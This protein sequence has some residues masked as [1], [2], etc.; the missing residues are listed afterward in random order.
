MTS[1]YL[2]KIYRL[3]I[4]E[5][6]NIFV[7]QNSDSYVILHNFSNKICLI[8]KKKMK[9]RLSGLIFLLILLGIS[10]KEQAEFSSFNGF[11][12]GTTYSVVFE[13][14]DKTDPS[15]LR[16]KVEKI[17]HDFDMS[18]S[19]YQDS[20]IVSRI[21]LNENVAPDSFFIEAFT[22]SKE[23]TRITGGA[24]DI[25]VGPLVEAW[26]FGP[27]ATKN[28]TVPIRDSLMNFIG[29]DKVEIRNGMVYKADPRIRLDFNAIAQG[30]SVDILS[31]YLNSI[32]INR[33][34]VE[35]G[36]EVRV[37]G[38]KGGV[39]WRIG[40]DRP[41]DNN[42]MPGEDMQAIIS[43]KDKSLATSGNYRKF[44]IEDGIKYS[45]TIDPKTGYPA[46]NRLLS[47]T[48]IADDC[49]TADGIATACMVM[50]QANTIEFLN[51]HPEFEAYLIYSDDNG[52]FKT[53]ATQ[54][55]KEY[56]SET[57]E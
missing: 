12:Q 27:G 15:D 50:G 8:N 51:L 6:K 40:I 34:L 21:N 3:T 19:L 36:G 39:L 56:I 13:N 57:E 31:R 17:L 30:Y 28:I 45:H 33:H 46:G 7:S 32:G 47:A 44:Y 1:G 52:N 49:A 9:I 2:K 18:L 38:D 54:N 5:Y 24:F 55:L 42:M 14:T 11:A 25:T 43:L 22:K 37:C 35:I 48:I 29:M 41:E 26:G 53:W 16:A 10:C 20:S 4:L 23:I